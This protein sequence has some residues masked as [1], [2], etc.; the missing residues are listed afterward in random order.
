LGYMD[1][2][3]LLLR[4]PDLLANFEITIRWWWL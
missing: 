2:R 4:M 3:G 1:F